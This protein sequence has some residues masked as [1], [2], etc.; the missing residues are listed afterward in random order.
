VTESMTTSSLFRSRLSSAGCLALVALLSACRGIDPGPLP[1]STQAGAIYAALPEQIDPSARYLIYVH[2]KIIEDQGLPAISPIFGEYRYQDILEAFQQAGFQV[3]SEIRQKG[4]DAT[5][6]AEHLASQVKQLLQAG[7]PADRITIV[8]ASQGAGIVIYASHL[9]GEP[10]LNY[11]LLAICN[12]D[13]VRQM[14][15]DQISLSGNVLS[16]YDQGDE[17]AGSCADLFS[18]SA[19]KGLANSDEI[20]LSM[21]LG[22]GL[23]Y[24]PYPEW[25]EPVIH[26]ALGQTA[27]Y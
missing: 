7:V 23:L 8:G 14:I 2:G 18:Y 22:H 16:I 10:E 1:T 21:E 27:P 24:Q 19:G 4:T 12:P 3:I 11:V 15:R 6:Y 5:S 9:L 26:W 20:Q 25:T 17:Y 13:E